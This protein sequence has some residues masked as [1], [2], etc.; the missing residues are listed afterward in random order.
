MKQQQ[1][2]EAACRL[3]QHLVAASGQTDETAT[4][5]AV[6]LATVNYFHDPVGD[7]RMPTTDELESL[8]GLYRPGAIDT[9]AIRNRCET[10]THAAPCTIARALDLCEQIFDQPP[11]PQQ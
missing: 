2:N 4:F 1:T 9:T 7:I 3:K 8:S 5:A 6:F 10:C 11:F